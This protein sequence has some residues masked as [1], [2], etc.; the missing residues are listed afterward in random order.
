[1]L[2]DTTQVKKSI[3]HTHY[4]HNKLEIIVY[5]PSPLPV[6][7]FF[8]EYLLSPL[9][10]RPYVVVL[11]SNKQLFTKIMIGLAYWCPAIV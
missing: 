1:M 7:C 8:L 2:G 10:S 6:R 3:W 5:V 4:T 9:S 11:C